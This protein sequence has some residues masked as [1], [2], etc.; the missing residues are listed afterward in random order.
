MRESL[1]N[2]SQSTEATANCTAVCGAVGAH[3][4]VL[5]AGV[6]KEVVQ[7]GDC[8]SVWKLAQNFAVVHT[9]GLNVGHM[10]VGRCLAR[11]RRCPCRFHVSPPG[12]RACPAG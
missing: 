5:G 10:R 9:A 8:V 12:D 11:G 3:G 6:R 1:R 7:R 4:E 2:S